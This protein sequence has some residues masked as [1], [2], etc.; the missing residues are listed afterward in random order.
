[1]IKSGKKWK[2]W[3]VDSLAYLLIIIFIVIFIYLSIERHNALKSYQNDLGVY[4]QITWNNLHGHFFESS[5]SMLA[6]TLKADGTTDE[7]HNYLS[8]HF[9][10]IMLL[11]VLFY[12][13]WPDPQ[14]FLIIQSIAV[15]IGA[16]PIYWLAKEKIKIWWGGLVFLISF[17]FYPILHNAL[18]YDF[19]EVTFAVPLVTFALW[20]WHKKRTGW[21]L[22]FL[23]LLFLVQ[24]HTALIVFMFGLLLI[25]KKQNWKLGLGISAVSLTYFFLVLLVFIPAFS[26]SGQSALINSEVPEIVA[27]TRYA[28]LGSNVNE[29]AWN[30][31]KHPILILQNMFSFRQ[32]DFFITLLLPVF[33]LPLFSSLTILI[34]P[35]LALYF[36]SNWALTYS[37]YYYHSSL[38]AGILYF[39][40]I[41][42][43]AR[44][45]RELKWQKIF[46]ILILISSL[47]ISYIYSVSP[48]G[49]DY[50]IKDYQPSENAKYLKE[51]KKLIPPEASLVVQQ[52]LGPHFA[53]RRKLFH[54]PVMLDKADYVVVDVYNPYADNPKS[55]YGFSNVR[56]VEYQIWRDSIGNLI[57]NQDFGVIY[58]QAE[59]LVFQKGADKNLNAKAKQDYLEAIK[60]LEPTITFDTRGN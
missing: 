13:F 7:N 45:F 16:L 58:D 25:L 37:V 56:E 54:F 2:I 5:G 22:F 40:A 23:A 9:S 28:W 53:T 27:P 57:D 33:A 47:I 8:G 17:L 43:F 36:L 39:S 29:I 18:L 11:F 52:N 35:V 60:R 30:I 32:V 55:F 51:V 31:V 46:L 20:F 21:M 19:H 26:A 6:A 49:K 50:S 42:V 34:L 41:L 38:L 59:W 3:S 10:P 4:S 12:L 24:E 44:F 48:F 1:M 15:G 14:V